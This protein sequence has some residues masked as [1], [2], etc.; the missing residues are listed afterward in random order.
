[1]TNET[2]NEGRRT[3]V[4]AC[5][6]YCCVLLLVVTCSASAQ[7]FRH[8]TTSNGQRSNVK[9]KLVG[10]NETTLRLQRE[11]NGRVV[12]LPIERLSRADREY[13]RGVGFQPVKATEDS[14]QAGSLRHVDR[15][16]YD[17]SIRPVLQ[18]FCG[19]CHGSE[20]QEAGLRLDGIDLD[21]A[22]R[23]VAMRWTEIMDRMNAGEMPPDDEP[24]PNAEQLTSVIEWITSELRH[25]EAAIQSTGGQVVMRRLNRAEYNNTIRDLIGI[26]F[27]PADDFPADPAC[28]RLRQH[29]RGAKCFSLC[30]WRSTWPPRERSSISPS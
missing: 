3:G 2:R 20:K 9:L 23:T 30:R 10:Q 16:A 21:F 1:M 4:L 25:R 8:W 27:R 22:K 17:V 29:R 5:V 26:D 24:Q 19:K 14:P 15:A 13:I 18:E 7:E 6:S 28:I 11:D 12:E